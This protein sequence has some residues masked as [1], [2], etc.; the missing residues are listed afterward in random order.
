MLGSGVSA[1][2][3]CW[4]CA[5]RLSFVD[6]PAFPQATV[7]GHA[8]EM[9]ACRIASV[10]AL[11]MIGRPHFYETGS[12]EGLAFAMRAIC[13]C[14][15]QV[16]ILTNASGGLSG[17]L[18]SG[19]IVIIRDHVALPALAGFNPLAGPNVGPGPRFPSMGGAYD[20]ELAEWARLAAVEFFIPCS[21][22][23][24]AMVAG[25]SYET[26]AELEY[27]ARLGVAVVGMSTAPEAIV[28][29]H[30][31]V[32]VLG[33][34]VVTNL[35]LGGATETEHRQ[36]LAAA[37]QAAPRLGQLIEGVVR[38]WDESGRAQAGVESGAP[39][40]PRTGL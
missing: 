28:A 31:G 40:S 26:G 19:D 12:M 15:V 36:V 25:P 35:A 27:L 14:G 13:A 32:R 7:E 9:A 29:R 2:T 18:R 3:E 22:G 38:R 33:L 34:S 24:Y 8:G 17:A 5:G 30:C 10:P 11:V 16:L 6:I 37:R 20:R 4:E 1:A 39:R 21:E 23:V